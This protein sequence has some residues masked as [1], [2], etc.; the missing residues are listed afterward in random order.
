M[1]ITEASFNT[2]GYPCFL[3][4]F[5]QSLEHFLLHVD[6]N[7]FPGCPNHLSKG[8]TKKAHS[9]SNIENRHSFLDVWG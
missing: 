3:C 4:P 1:L 9:T 5:L 6:T 2:S 7:D 8:N